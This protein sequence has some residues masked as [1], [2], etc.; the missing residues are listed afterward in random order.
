MATPEAIKSA[1]VQDR[2]RQK[3]ERIGVRDVVAS[4]R[5]L[6]VDVLRGFARGQISFDEQINA[7]TLRLDE[8]LRGGLVA[9]H[10][11]G[12]VRSIRSVE[13]HLRE[14]GDKQLNIYAK[15][16]EFAQARLK[17]TDA[18]IATIMAKYSIHATT[19]TSQFKTDLEGALTKSVARSIEMGET[20][21]Q[22][23]ARIRRAMSGVTGE[24]TSPHQAETIYRTQVNMSYSAGRWEVSQDPDVQ[25]ILW[26]F[27][28]VDLDDD[29][30]RAA[31]ELLDGTKLPK[32]DPQWSTIW[33]PNG[34][35]CRCTT[36]EIFDTDVPPKNQVGL[37]KP[38]MFDGILV[39][40][41]PDPGFD[42]N[43]GELFGGGIRTRKLNP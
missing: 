26:G 4:G 17:L 5:D 20:K 11:A 36:I 10:L 21:Q 14:T 38:K 42:F 18:E 16:T 31:H 12:M 30:V 13:D 33:T 9:A 29:R 19:I 41:E 8:A 7:A 3:L 23:Q 37:P 40:P 34:F 22:G 28:Y 1:Q 15:A 27:E 35:N 32:D 2:E 43:P 6:R 25:D 39:K 24:E